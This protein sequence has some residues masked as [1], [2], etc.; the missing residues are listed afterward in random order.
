MRKLAH[1][2]DPEKKLRTQKA[3]CQANVSLVMGLSFS[4][5]Q[6]TENN[7]IL[8]MTVETEQAERVDPHLL[9]KAMT[10][11]MGY[12]KKTSQEKKA[13]LGSESAVQVNFGLERVPEKASNKPIRIGIPHSLWR[14]NNGNDED[15]MQEPDVCLIVKEDSKEWV[16]AMIS[17]FPEQMSF[18]KKVLGLDSLRKK[19][20]RYEQQR[21]LLARFD[22]FMA[23]DRILP[24]LA[25]AIGRN[26]FRTKK[27]P[28]PIKLARKSALPYVI[29]QSLR[30]TFL[31]IPEGTTVTVR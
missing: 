1:R 24:M 16:Q 18:V 31:F 25:K 22:V 5:T 3:F 29:I 21:A 26:F 23:D 13:L 30:S 6:L 14:T 19:H 7:H 15:G 28:I 17:Q 10:A 11:L 8:M 9:T 4:T 20:S 12:H 27:Q 2:V